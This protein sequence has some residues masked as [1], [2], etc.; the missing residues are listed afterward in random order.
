MRFTRQVEGEEK[1]NI[2]KKRDPLKKKPEQKTRKHWMSEHIK[3]RNE[4]EAKQR[5]RGH[6]REQVSEN[7]SHP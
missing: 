3:M 2:M 5:A 6:R 7:E 1:K 4:E